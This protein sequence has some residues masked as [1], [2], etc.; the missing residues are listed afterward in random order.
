[1]KV[2]RTIRDALSV[3]VWAVGVLIAAGFMQS[4]ARAQTPPPIPYGQAE[5]PLD[6]VQEPL[7][8]TSL[9]HMAGDPVRPVTWRLVPS[10]PN[11]PDGNGVRPYN[12]SLLEMIDPCRLESR[13]VWENGTYRWA[14]YVPSGTGWVETSSPGESAGYHS[15]M[16]HADGSTTEI[17]KWWIQPAQIY[18]PFPNHDIG[19][20]VP[21][22]FRS[23]ANPARPLSTGD[24]LPAAATFDASSL[25]LLPGSLRGGSP[26]WNG[27]SRP[28]LD[29]KVDL[30]TGVPIIRVTDLELPFG[31][32]T[33]RLTRTR[34][35]GPLLPDGESSTD[36]RRFPGSPSDSWWDWT[37]VGWMTGESPV[38]LI[39]SALPDIVGNNPKTTRMVLDAHTSIPFQ[40]IE[41]TGNYE[42]PPRF[43]ATL[44]HNGSWSTQSHSWATPPSEYK[45]SLYEGELTYTFVA[46]REDVPENR[47]YPDYLT[48]PNGEIGGTPEETSSHDRP[49]LPQHFA[50]DP[51]PRAAHD[52]WNPMINP[53]AGIPY[54]GICT[55]IQDRNG[56][57]VRMTYH[58]STR[59]HMDDPAT[60]D[61]IECR[62]DTL[63]K[64]QLKYIKLYA[65]E[66]SVA[67]WT[68]V[69]G[70]RKFAGINWLPNWTEYHEGAYDIVTAKSP[71][72]D[73]GRYEVHGDIAIDRVYAYEG[74]IAAEVLDPADLTLP[75]TN[76]PG[77]SSGLG[78]AEHDPLAVYNDRV[79]TT[80]DLPTNWKHQ[81]RYHY[82]TF[83]SL[84][85]AW[86]QQPRDGEQMA[87][88]YRWY[89][90]VEENATGMMPVLVLTSM[91]T[92]PTMAQPGV[93]ASSLRAYVY[94]QYPR[95]NPH[96][97]HPSEINSRM[98]WLR[99]YLEDR[100][101]R[102]VVSKCEHVQ[103]ASDRIA[104]WLWKI[105]EEGPALESVLR[106][107][108]TEWF[109]PV[110]Y[111]ND[112]AVLYPTL[113]ML[114]ADGGVYTSWTNSFSD[115][116]QKEPPQS[117]RG[118]SVKGHWGPARHYIIRRFT[119][120]QGLN[121]APQSSVWFAPYAW[122]GHPASITETT[123]A[124][125][126]ALP[127]LEQP[128]FVVVIDEYESR[129]LLVQS[130]AGVQYMGGVHGSLGQMGANTPTGWAPVTL[131]RRI[132]QISASG[133]VLKERKWSYNPGGVVVTGS[134][135]GEDFKYRRIGELFS[136][137]TEDPACVHIPG[138]GQPPSNCGTGG[139]PASV[140]NE[141]VLVEHRSLGWS[142]AELGDLQAGSPPGSA[143]TGGRYENGLVKFY[144]YGLIGTGEIPWRSRVQVVAEGIQKG[145][146]L[147]PVF[148]NQQPSAPP[149]N[150]AT[151]F[152][153][154]QVFFA[155]NNSDPQRVA[156]EITFREPRA[157]FPSQ[158]SY[159]A[160]KTDSTFSLTEFLVETTTGEWADRKV[161]SRTTVRPPR[162]QRPG[163][164]WYSPI[165]REE[166]DQL[167][168]AVWVVTGLVQDHSD[169][170]SPS[171]DPD[172]SLMFNYTQYDGLGMPSVVCVDVVP[173]TPVAS[174]EDSGVGTVN[175]PAVS[176]TMSAWTRRGGGT[177]P[178]GGTPPANYVTVTKYD[179]YGV[180]DI[181]YPG[182]TPGSKG[183]RFAR[184]W[185]V[186]CPE[187]V[188]G[189]QYRLPEA[190]F[191]DEFI[192]N[193]I[194]HIANGQFTTQS[195]GEHRVYPG[196]KPI[197]TPQ[198][199]RRGF[200]V[201]SSASGPPSFAIELEAR[202]PTTTPDGVI[203]GTAGG[204]LPPFSP[205]AMVTY[206]LDSDGRP[207]QADL[208]EIAFDGSSA[209]VG[210][211]WLNELVDVRR[212]QEIDGTITRHTR[213]L[214]G[215]HMRTY[216]G[217]AD[218]SWQ[219]DEAHVDP[220]TG[221]YLDPDSNPG[222]PEEPV[223]NMVIAERFE[224]GGGVNDA[225]LP[226]SHR[227]YRSHD[228]S[229]ADKFYL[230]PEQHQ[231]PIVD[232]DG[233]ATLTSYDWQRRP[234][235]VDVYDKGEPGT[236]SRLS[237]T[238][239]YLDL[240]GRPY[241]VATFGAGSL[242]LS[243][244]DPAG[245]LGSEGPVEP[246]ELYALSL[247]PHT[248]VRTQYGPDGTANIVERYAVPESGTAA[249]EFQSE[250]HYFGIA[251]KEVFTQT[252]G[253]AVSINTIDA[254]GRVAKASTVAPG[255]STNPSTPY[256]Y[257]LTRTEY[258]YDF[259]G[260]VLEERRFDRAL[261]SGDALVAGAAGNA[262]LSR[263]MS[264]YDS[265]RRLIAAAELGTE[266][267][268][269]FTVGEPTASFAWASG[270][271]TV[272]VVAG[273]PGSVSV[274]VPSGL[275]GANLSFSKYDD[276]T[277]SLLYT[278]APDQTVTE[279]QYG[280]GNRITLKI[281]N[282]TALQALRRTTE[283]TYQWARLNRMIA[284]PGIDP[285]SPGPD[286]ALQQASAV[287]YGADVVDENF[288]VVSRNNGLVGAFHL[289]NK[290]AAGAYDDPSIRL[291]YTFQGQ[292]AE[293]IDP[294]GVVFRY[295]YD[296]LD[297]LSSVE[298][299][300]DGQSGSTD[301][302]PPSMN[303][304]AP[305]G[306]PASAPVDRIGFVQ[307]S[308]CP[309]SGRLTRVLAKTST[310]VTATVISDTT[311][312]YDHYGNLLKETQ[313]LGQ[314]AAS[315]SPAISYDW[316]HTP[317]L[318]APDAT[319]RNRLIGM[320]Y[321]ALDT[322][323]P[324]YV[325][326]GYGSSGT[327]DEILSRITSIDTN[328]LPSGSSSSVASLGYIGSGRRRSITIGGQTTANLE[329]LTGGLSGLDRFGRTMDLHYTT[330]SGANLRTLYRA[331]Y[332]FDAAGNRLTARIDRAASA[333]TTEQNVWSQLNAYNALGQLTD[334][335]F[336]ALDSGGSA[337]S[338]GTRR[339]R[340]QWWLDA[341]GN[342]NARPFMGDPLVP[343]GRRIT[344]VVG[345]VET[346]VDITDVNDNRN[347]VRE[348]L[349]SRVSTAPK[350]RYDSA[351]NLRSD[352]VY[353]Y[354]YDAWN[355]LVQINQA[356]VNP[357]APTMEPTS[358]D[359][360]PLHEEPWFPGVLIKHF[361]YD[362]L[363]RLAET[364]SP[365]PSPQAGTGD[366]RTERFFYDGIR[367][368]QE[369][370]IDPI[371][372]TDSSLAS[373][374]P[375]LMAAATGEP[376]AVPGDGAT[377]SLELE[378]FQDDS[379]MSYA[380]L[381]REYIWGPGD[382]GIDELLA[383]YDLYRNPWWMLTDDGGDVVA[384]TTNTGPGGT[385]AVAA[386]WTY[387]AYG[388]V[389]AQNIFNAG[390]PVN[391][392]GHKGL[393]ADRLD[394][395]VV[396]GTSGPDR[397]RLEPG[398]KL[399]YQVRN[400]AYSPELGRWLQS[401]P[402]ATGMVNAQMAHHGDV[403]QPHS[404]VLEIEETL[405]DGFNL[406]EYLR[407]ASGVHSDP[408]GLF[409]LEA[410]G[411][412]IPSPSDVV[413]GMY[414][415]LLA[416]YAQN[417]S[418]DVQW[419]T[420]WDM[421]DDMHSRID[422]KWIPDAIAYGAMSA[423]AI[424]IPFTEFEFNPFLDTMA[425]QFPYKHAKPRGKTGVHGDRILHYLPMVKLFR[426]WRSVSGVTGLH[427]HKALRDQK[428]KTLRGPNGEIIVPDVQF[429]YK[430][431]LY[432]RELVNTH[433]VP[434]R[435]ADIVDLLN[436]NGIGA[437]KL[438]YKEP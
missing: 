162:R 425:T 273:N 410:L 436:H 129:D 256:A 141:Q 241:L 173:G 65:P 149:S 240:L 73:P 106:E 169:P 331:Q 362:G 3:L 315:S 27:L 191:V 18:P 233:Y 351:G 288:A 103:A 324:R 14:S 275:E 338:S 357:N 120:T 289:P 60:P 217:T 131:S 336:G 252:P 87:E 155:D 344:E 40:L 153:T 78:S 431:R 426:K 53:G 363:G 258:V 382:R 75:H 68:L 281:E 236:A 264:W 4:E 125:Q 39:D 420:D 130:S 96:W 31:S 49:L 308:Y 139:I 309:R 126:T 251:D 416:G 200:F 5:K 234:V 290:A 214:I 293:R 350:F 172:A 287:I 352:G 255:R 102:E 118:A 381:E 304:P 285:L 298:V 70:Y 132:I 95:R 156:A 145:S 310:D 208:I 204:I 265:E 119:N 231:T 284:W 250:H 71:E 346:T 74:D 227:K 226:V 160:Q 421:P 179:Q 414:T 399:V 64:G 237:T 432:V 342:W 181:F 411:A 358:E 193:N 114:H 187:F 366:V 135:I 148:P 134:G 294:R 398:A 371:M 412:V 354:Q 305:L 394:V 220:S 168:Q 107:A 50:N 80:V 56:H 302:Y 121:A 142:V 157:L 54:L 21:Y 24:F 178:T 203:T 72:E 325:E 10:I 113:E 32:A 9:P 430:G 101:L 77:L 201:A 58:A 11:V 138:L 112:A 370:V 392:C 199:R 136:H 372:D 423:F 343:P 367:R 368:I 320:T 163:G 428:G 104:E 380:R 28:M 99:G 429:W 167:G 13:V 225:R 76:R 224:Y 322:L 301:G 400:R 291:R 296:A 306:S 128:R 144:E 283:Y 347:R 274:T 369:R 377:A 206:K 277:G 364:Q 184:R 158:P 437:S 268:T 36:L 246:A 7:A 244:L 209:A 90:G 387:D 280:K 279:Y 260:N 81:V 396:T 110:S 403:S 219:G 328:F 253:G 51:G 176:G 38:L 329:S 133:V 177:T 116:E 35:S 93:V 12:P 100:E 365:Y 418:W 276:T 278:V 282:A 326:F 196:Q 355:R 438:D 170:M 272:N 215:Q 286:V 79:T 43:R 330:D 147:G 97:P 419:A 154:R 323:A 307:Y 413:R 393:F 17:A 359:P 221:E 316:E 319:G 405:G 66:Q 269:G 143:P 29:G 108:C 33:F 303:T 232:D 349:D 109:E 261:S 165:V 348:R 247:R 180:S 406:Y 341:L 300:T 249:P 186:N 20:Y 182:P 23:N 360:I 385:A 15:L 44:R 62:H 22:G 388:A 434:G 202:Q 34:A 171:V 435:K 189:S 422:N 146:V 409:V 397:L 92:R 45:V 262:V 164:P 2:H 299:R 248:I 312:E 48:D 243:G 207:Q 242:D 117:V 337:I 122:R 151:K 6:R 404:G 211:K 335:D 137:L 197:G 379:N 127:N 373:G 313:E 378:N 89:F 192:Y 152:Y 140:Y 353:F 8:T 185:V 91:H 41:T 311:F 216:V 67:S 195:A 384:M 86:G 415:A 267:T 361:K 19:A 1:M 230:T 374:E 259:N 424:G 390:A 333:L 332:A 84:E 389:I 183:P 218:Q 188:P 263:S 327:E 386:Q 339:H 198:E 174:P 295:R 427:M 345:S 161:T 88:R 213:N 254:L 115:Y 334:S 61:C 401:D 124:Q 150:V 37:G 223:H 194:T 190:Q 85:G 159:D 25:A 395:P 105:S 222:T 123:A 55:Q 210:S 257:E 433:H 46:I 321:P 26:A 238:L 205:M 63:R 166:Y 98:P 229:W 82:H 383:Q 69:Y 391:R 297:R 292:I 42:A 314:E 376:G 266:M 245:L 175:V 235:R 239:T 59:Q 356:I 402:N 271:P 270:P 417:L 94:D 83:R 16:F 57:L 375:G 228:R 318:S 407:S 30:I 212:E 317:T 408:L 340:D 47:W 111:E 52:P